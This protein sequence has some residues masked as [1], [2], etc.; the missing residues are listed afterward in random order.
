VDELEG[1]DGLRGMHAMALGA[2]LMAGANPAG[3]HGTD[4]AISVTVPE[5]VWNT[6][7]QFAMTVLPDGEV[8]VVD[9]R[10]KSPGWSIT[11]H[12]SPDGSSTVTV[13]G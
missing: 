6:P 1:V 2:V 3:P 9:S 10:T 13:L 11:R 8:Q 4:M 12:V 7:N 5:T